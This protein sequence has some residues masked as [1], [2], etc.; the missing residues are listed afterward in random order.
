[1]ECQRH[2]ADS[3]VIGGLDKYLR[4]WAKETTDK[5]G[6]PELLAHFHALQLAEPGYAEWNM[7]KR[8]A[9][10][11]G[12]LDWLGQMEEA[13]GVALSTEG[14]VSTRSTTHSPNLSLIHI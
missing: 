12:V 7:E 1:M 11:K 5:T 6:S 4:R 2:Y 3:V 9:W 10:V 8:K 14:G 13:T